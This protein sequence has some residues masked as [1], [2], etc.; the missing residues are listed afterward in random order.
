MIIYIYILYT[1]L[2][3][4]Y[5]VNI[6]IST[7]VNPWWKIPILGRLRLCPNS[8]PSQTICRASKNLQPSRSGERWSDLWSR[9][10]GGMAWRLNLEVL[11]W[12]MCLQRLLL[13]LLDNYMVLGW[14]KHW[15]HAWDLWCLLTSSNL[16]VGVKVHG[17]QHDTLGQEIPPPLPSLSN[18]AGVD[19]GW[20]RSHDIMSFAVR[21]FCLFQE[22]PG[23]WN[24]VS[25]HES[26]DHVM[27][28]KRV[29]KLSLWKWSWKI[30]AQFC[31]VLTLNCQFF[32]FL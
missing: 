24:I 14:L 17:M 5:T 13:I 15:W 3:A 16:V 20:P 9:R 28:L 23:W 6:D 27:A 31:R 32:S 12:N 30:E 29:R 4:L 2:Y 25:H 8:S 22:N 19:G 11:R 18:E 21:K 26:H 10:L 7:I 1:H